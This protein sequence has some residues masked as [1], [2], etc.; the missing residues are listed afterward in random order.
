MVI[1]CLTIFLSAVLLFQVELIIGKYI[2]PWFGGTS[3][4]WIT[5]MLFFQVLLLAGYALGHLLQRF[6]PRL[7]SRIHCLFLIA[8][9]SILIGQFVLWH[10]PLILDS[11]WRPRANGNPFLQVLVLLTVSVGLP[12]LVLASSGPTLQSWWSRIYFRRSPYRLYALSNFGSLL[13]L[14]SY[15]FLVEPFIR[16]KT[17]AR[18]WAWAYFAFA[19]G[20]G[21]CAFRL[22]RATEAAA[23]ETS[24]PAQQ[25]FTV[26]QRSRP[27]ADVLILWLGLAGCASAM[28]LSTTNQ[29]C[30]NVAPVP[31][32]WILPLAIYLL[33]FMLCFESER[34]YSR[35]WFHPAF[36]ISILLALFVL[37][38]SNTR[39]N[40]LFQIA[41]YSVVLFVGCML[42]HGE[43]AR[44]K[45]DPR[46]LTLFY[47]LIAAGG[48]LGGLFVGLAAPYFFSMY[49]E[50]EI[51]LW[52]ATLLLLLVLYRDH[53]SWFYSARLKPHLM[54]IGAAA[55]VPESM[56]AG[57]GIK[58]L[59]ST[60]MY[61]V[62]VCLAF[63]VLLRGKRSRRIGVDRSVIA[64]SCAFV[65]IVLASAFLVAG[66]PPRDRVAALRNFYGALTVT[67]RN[68]DDP[69]LESYALEHG[70]IMHGFEFRAPGRRLIPTAYFTPDSGLGLVFASR[71][72]SNPAGLESRGLRIGVVGLGVGTIAAYGREGDYI[73]FYEIN[74]AVLRF[75]SDT[76]Y[77]HYVEQCP[78][79]VDFV[80]GDARL[81]LEQE[82]L[83]GAHEDFDILAIDAFSGDAP[84]I[85]MLTEEAFKLYFRRLRYP[86]GI[87]AVNVTNRILDL[88][89][90]AAAAAS[91]LGLVS[92][93]VHT[94]G[95]REISALSD[96][97]LVSRDP[98]VISSFAAT[99]KHASRLQPSEH[100]LWTD[101]YSNLFLALAK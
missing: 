47:L 57:L 77:F 75:A 96:W 55:L 40:L 93:W 63:L 5:C 12:F 18:I 8:S 67:H 81:S 62:I 42:C 32:L 88:K 52:L 37:V 72:S 99:A 53:S 38:S 3:A 19:V 4:V 97:V 1:F 89:Q 80:Q 41:V 16:L 13:A 28:F 92:L 2:L 71:S 79:K 11:Y 44:L 21:F 15:P 60:L 26:G 65:L 87:L 50:Y 58:Q 9:A 25:T 101:D 95:D 91:Q 22:S 82:Y 24:M 6:R 29:L 56:A 43:L 84:P 66:R 86:G 73:R 69:L 33:T 68:P 70:E 23:Q 35:K 98:A 90:V 51:S 64:A 7:Q 100:E 10:S 54:L 14:I 61:A 36:F 39:W 85:H 30:K 76:R 83:S 94:D 46:H 31:L 27:G 49:W 20:I 45:P 17:Q 74:P 59:G 78:A 34:R 48:V